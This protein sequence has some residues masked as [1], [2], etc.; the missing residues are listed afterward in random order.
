LEV[1]RHADAWNEILEY[2]QILP[3]QCELSDEQVNW[4]TT[5]L[6]TRRPLIP[7]ELPFSEQANELIISACTILWQ[8][9]S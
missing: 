1:L 5:E 4:L 6:R 7:T 3:N 8:E 9:F 2:L